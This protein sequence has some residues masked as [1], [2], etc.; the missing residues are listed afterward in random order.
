MQHLTL[1]MQAVGGCV[2]VHQD[3]QHRGPQQV[4]QEH[5]QKRHGTSKTF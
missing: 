3:R 2:G 1:W 4:R 5:V